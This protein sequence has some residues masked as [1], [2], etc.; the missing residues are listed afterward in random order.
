MNKKV[1]FFDSVSV[2]IFALA[3][4]LMLLAVWYS[5]GHGA[6]LSGDSTSYLYVADSLS[7]GL[8]FSVDNEPSFRRGPGYP[9][10][11]ALTRHHGFLLVTQISQSLLD[12]LSAFFIFRIGA[13]LWS[14]KVGILA[15]L[16]YSIHYYAIKQCVIIMPETLFVFFVVVSF[17]F[18]YAG[19]NQQSYKKIALAGLFASFAVLTKEILV[20]YYIAFGISTLLLE[21]GKGRRWLMGATVLFLGVYILSLAPWI[22]RSSLAHKRLTLWTDVSGFTLYLGNNPTVNPRLKGEDWTLK[23][24][25]ALP[26]DVSNDKVYKDEA[27]RYIKAQPKI[28]IKNA[29]FKLGRLWYPVYS[30]SPEPI[31]FY[32]G[33]LF[34]YMVLFAGMGL[35]GNRKRW[36]E[37][38]PFWGMIIYLSCINS[39]TIA[40]I[41]YRFVLEPFL[42]LLAAS[43]AGQIRLH[44]C[45]KKTKM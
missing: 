30:D 16:S 34:I 7:N 29:L 11:L 21:G 42:L 32:S 41:R 45:L 27:V 12:A 40:S 43:S 10:F 38:L 5:S 35:W 13:L 1:L 24:N 9:L 17:Y 36:I 4:R 28:F 31:K 26:P 20:F 2:F 6:H 8:G 33:V 23:V 14:R 39:I 22:L 15:G 44:C 3:L 18:Y 37:L 25:T 19:R